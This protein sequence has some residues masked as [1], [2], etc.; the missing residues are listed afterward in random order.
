MLYALLLKP[1]RSELRLKPMEAASCSAQLDMRVETQIIKTSGCDLWN[2]NRFAI[3]VRANACHFLGKNMQKRLQNAM[4]NTSWLDNMQLELS[5]RIQ[6]FMDF[7][8]QTLGLPGFVCLGVI[9]VH[10]WMFCPGARGC[11]IIKRRPEL[12]PNPMYRCK[13]AWY[14][15]IYLLTST[16]NKHVPYISIH[17]HV[18]D[19]FCHADGLGWVSSPPVFK[20]A[21]KKNARVHGGQSQASQSLAIFMVGK[22]WF[23]SHG[24]KTNQIIMAAIR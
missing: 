17:G 11:Y 14:L 21:A 22:S 18:S 7:G 4:N 12:A 3:L 2:I 1:R 6:E 5:K 13:L 23:V 19:S 20:K 16:T 24:R 10:C 9:G 15:H 8:F